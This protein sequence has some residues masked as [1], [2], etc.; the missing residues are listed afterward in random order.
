MHD[1]YSLWFCLRVLPPEDDLLLLEVAPVLLIHQHKIQEVL[2]REDIVDRSIGRGEIEIGK[3][4]SDRNTFAYIRQL[5]M[6]AETCL[7][8]VGV[9]PLIGAPSISSNLIIFSDSL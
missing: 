6:N 4:E 7:A 5:V 2:N 1:A 9:I 3:E 8:I